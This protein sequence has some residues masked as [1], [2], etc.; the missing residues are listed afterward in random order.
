MQIPSVNSMFRARASAV[1][2][3]ASGQLDAGFAGRYAAVLQTAAE[4]TGGTAQEPGTVQELSIAEGAAVPATAQT[5]QAITLPVKT[6]SA[7][8]AYGAA[9][10]FIPASALSQTY[11]AGGDAALASQVVAYAK[12]FVGTPYV[13]G[14]EDLVKG[15]DCSGFVQS[16]YKH[17]GISLPRSS[18]QQSKVGQ[19]VSV[20]DL[21]PG[22]LLFF[23]TDDYAPVTHVAMYIGDGKIVHASSVKTGVI[24][25][26][27]KIKDDF[28]IARRLL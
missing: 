21:Q 18:Y 8:K 17:F 5:R 11:M 3:P 22:D 10:L 12:Q 28:R 14:G 20:N 27:L 6:A 4:Q 13:A 1:G 19:E 26:K 7:A 24:I 25:S 23:K 15:A 16:V 2:I 9:P